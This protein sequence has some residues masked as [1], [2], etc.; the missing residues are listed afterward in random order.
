MNKIESII[1][2]AIF[3]LIVATGN[4]VFISIAIVSSLFYMWYTNDNSPTDSR[5]SR[6]IKHD[7]RFAL[8]MQ[9]KHSYMKSSQWKTK[10]AQAKTRDCYTCV[11]CGEIHNLQVHHTS[12]YMLIPNEPLYM[13]VTLCEDCHTDEHNKYE[14]P[15][16]YEDYKNWNHPVNP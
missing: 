14:Y 11:I 2:I 12:G 15:K 5:L 8:F 10:R 16:T 13:L 1:A 6:A 7:T 9:Q 4:V 3:L